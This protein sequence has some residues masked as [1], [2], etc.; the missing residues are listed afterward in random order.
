MKEEDIT[1]IYWDIALCKLLGITNH[2]IIEDNKC[3]WI[4]IRIQRIRV[5]LP[6]TTNY[7]T[8]KRIIKKELSKYTHHNPITPKLYQMK[9]SKPISKSSKFDR[10]VKQVP[11]LDP[12]Y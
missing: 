4:E 9:K 3:Q 7:K 12:C 5:T 6:I 10:I 1:A 2:K 11:L 8:I